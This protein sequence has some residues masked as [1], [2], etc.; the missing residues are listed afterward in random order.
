MYAIEG[1]LRQFIEES[2]NGY[3]RV[4]DNKAEGFEIESDMYEKRPQGIMSSLF[5]NLAELWPYDGGPDMDLLNI[6]YDLSEM[7]NVMQSTERLGHTVLIFPGMTLDPGEK[8]K[9]AA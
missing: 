2:S 1:H 6:L 3:L 8:A 4:I 5:D 7:L 9:K